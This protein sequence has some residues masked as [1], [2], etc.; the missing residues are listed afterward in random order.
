MDR[1]TR[2]NQLRAARRVFVATLALNLFVALSKLGW[3]FFTNTLSMI[4]DGFHSLLD[5]SSNV[6]GII[7]L[8]ISARPPD[9]DHPYGHRKFE[10]VAAICISFLM[11]LASY[12][13]LAEAVP[14]LILHTGETPVVSLPSYVIL[15]VTA[16]I[17]VAVSYYERKRGTELNSPLLL[18][19]SQHTLS[20]VFVSG[21]VLVSL[22]AIQLSYPVVDVIGSLLVVVVILRAGFGI[23]V[24]NLG[25][26]VDA[27]MLDPAFIESIVLSVPGVSG[28]HRIRSRGLQDSIFIDLHVQVS[29]ALSIQEAHA[30]STLVE[31]TIKQRAGGVVDVLV[32]IEEDSDPPESI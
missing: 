12:E 7:G 16:A 13:V 24:A 17:N 1:Q 15:L 3:G 23:I 6:V 22:A 14:R 26:L 5:A 18:A 2:V 29:P 30:I 10:A 9:K 28:C 20:D 31:Q 11:F 27:A 19:D 25:S 8:T 32:H 21:A 4:A